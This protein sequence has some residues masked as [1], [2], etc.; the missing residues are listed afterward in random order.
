[1]SA[2][3]IDDTVRP[4]TRRR[5][6]AG[7]YPDPF[8]PQNRQRWWNGSEWTEFDHPLR[9]DVHVWPTEEFGMPVR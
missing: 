9:P 7:W 3:V 8:D 2:A 4:A 6:D 5:P 1:M